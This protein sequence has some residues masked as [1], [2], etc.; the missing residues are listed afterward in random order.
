M[1]NSK[2]RTRKLANNGDGRV[3]FSCLGW[4]DARLG[5]PFRYDLPGATVAQAWA[6]ENGRLRVLTLREKGLPVPA[7]NAAYTVPPKVR[8][9]FEAANKAHAETI[10]SGGLAC[11]P[12]GKSHW[13]PA[14]AGA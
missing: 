7:W 4:E 13:L 5:R 8:S 10:L 11:A 14:E 2:S 1:L 9:A 6:Y 3:P 12:H